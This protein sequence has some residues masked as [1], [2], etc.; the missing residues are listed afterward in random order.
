[1]HIDLL[2]ANEV[3][4]AGPMM[5]RCSPLLAFFGALQ[6]KSCLV[7]THL[8]VLVSRLGLIGGCT[9]SGLARLVGRF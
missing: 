2:D 9:D 7:R 6:H 8:R 1:M 5:S 4:Q 3:G